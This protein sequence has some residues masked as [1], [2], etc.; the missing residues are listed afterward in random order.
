MADRFVPDWLRPRAEI[1]PRRTALIFESSVWSFAELDRLVDGA[2]AFLEE[3]GVARG[4]RIGLHAEN[5]AGFVV[6]VHALMRIGAVLVPSNTRLTPHEVEWQ[7]RDADISLVVD[8]AAAATLMDRSGAAQ[9]QRR[10]FDL[11]NEWHSIVY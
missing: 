2:A 3:R 5:S 11:D 9:R 6:A 8:D 4:Q 1:T 10:E 7:T